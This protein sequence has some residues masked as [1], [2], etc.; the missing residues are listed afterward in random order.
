MNLKAA[1]TIFPV[2]MNRN[3]V[4]MDQDVGAIRTRTAGGWSAPRNALDGQ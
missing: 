2:H 4:Q 3:A 1:I